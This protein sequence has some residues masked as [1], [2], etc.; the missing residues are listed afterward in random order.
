M[1]DCIASA[2]VSFSRELTN[3]EVRKQV[4]SETG[5]EV[6]RMDNFSLVAINTLHRLM[7]GQHIEGNLGLYSAAQYFSVDLLQGL[8][9]GIEQGDEMRPVDFISTVGNTANY[10]MAKLFNVLGPNIFIGTSR[11]ASLKLE[12]LS[13]C[14]LSN[15]LV[16]YA[17]LV[18]W[19]DNE[20][21]YQCE[22]KL[23]TLR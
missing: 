1:L 7:A 18:Q 17:L 23:L 3:K 16:D 21:S 12:L 8:L 13:Q 9:T 11:D 19:H 14:D 22:A 6:R 20:T 4:K 2:S 5:L 15:K 10:Y